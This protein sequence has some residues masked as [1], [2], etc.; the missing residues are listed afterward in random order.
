MEGRENRSPVGVLRF[1]NG[2]EMKVLGETSRYWLCEGAQF[3]KNNP[4]I[5]AVIPAKKKAK[6]KKSPEPGTGEREE[7]TNAQAE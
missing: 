2:Q 3:R 4:Q 5:A 1:T 6:L 7:D